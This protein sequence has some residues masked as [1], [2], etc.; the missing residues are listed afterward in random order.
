MV[1]NNFCNVT[2][3][4]SKCNIPCRYSYFRKIKLFLYKLSN[5][6]TPV[7]IKG[8][9]RHIRHVEDR[10]KGDV[11]VYYVMLKVEE[12][13]E[14]RANGLEKDLLAHYGVNSVEEF[15][16][17]LFKPLITISPEILEPIDKLMLSYGAKSQLIYLFC[18]SV[19]WGY[20]AF[21]G[22]F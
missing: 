3:D 14:A 2:N 11:S 5:I 22:F 10:Q 1:S 19:G 15:R 13:E 4:N 20:I 16:S 8:N 18:Y 17:M 6:N 21:H 12:Y 9:N 7:N